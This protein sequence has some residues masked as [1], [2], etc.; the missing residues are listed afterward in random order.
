[1]NWTST[2]AWLG[3]AIRLVLGGVWIWAS[4][5]KLHD[6]R[7]FLRAV[8]AYDATPDWLSKAIAYG[9]PIV[10][11]I[12]GVLLV[13]GLLTRVMASIS[14]VLYI[15]FLIGLIQAAARGIK[16]Q[17]GCFGG[18]GE[19]DSTSYLLDSFRDILLLAGAAF[20]IIYPLTRWSLDLYFT[21]HDQVLRPSAKRMRTEE[22]RRKY[23][24]QVAHAKREARIRN[25]WLSAGVAVVMV[26]VVAI[27]ISVQAGRAKI[28]GDIT[29]P[30]A[31]V[32]SG[33]TVG[34]PKAPVVMDIY[35]DFQCPIC[36][37]FEQSAGEMITSD[38]NSGKVLAHYH[39]M[40]FLDGSSNGNRYSSRAANAAICASDITPQ[41]FLSMHNVLYGKDKNGNN[42]QPAEGTNGRTD[43]ELIAF[44]T[45][46]GVTGS[47]TSAFTTCVTSEMH[48]A[49]VQ[50]LTDR[51]NKDGV[52][53]T[54]TIK[55]NGK[56]VSNPSKDTVAAAIDAASKGKTNA[57][58]LTPVP[59]PA[60][61]AASAS[62]GS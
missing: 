42:N 53:G 11:L 35:E 56:L 32:A 57:P 50:A 36:N 59:S 15:V 43:S 13:I 44:G 12:V 14:A 47:Y 29:A 26:L 25:T 60:P 48:K 3:T 10:E 5:E 24:V 52:N 61:A 55:V 9:L 17:C 40:S 1:M 62:A 30:N 41:M 21:R 33:V 4:I 39:V 2:R 34:A 22:G 20:L 31:T 49:L 7:T 54:P 16:L 51:A 45:Q 28:T 8:R 38:I 27:G 6:P 58:A 18:G 46:A 23:E 19:S 37:Q